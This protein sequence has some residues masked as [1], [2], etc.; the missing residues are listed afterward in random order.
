MRWTSSP[1]TGPKRS[2]FTWS[3]ITFKI[4]SARPPPH[5]W[6]ATS[7][8]ASEENKMTSAGIFS[9]QVLVN[10][11]EADTQDF[12]PSQVPGQREVWPACHQADTHQRRWRQIVFCIT[13]YPCCVLAWFTTANTHNCIA[14]W[15][16]HL[17]P[18]RPCASTT[19]REE[20]E[21]YC[22]PRI[23]LFYRSR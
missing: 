12:P 20:A 9:W 22:D 21:N 19:V 6:S 18:H 13:L 3:R 10:V 16:N 17:R 8:T 11:N 23:S 4:Y 1:S 5:F 15:I 2:P 7:T 14:Y